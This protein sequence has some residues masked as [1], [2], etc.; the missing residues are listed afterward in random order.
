MVLLIERI[1]HQLKS[2]LSQYLQGFIHSTSCRSSSINS[3]VSQ[4]VCNTVVSGYANL[5]FMTHATEL[6]GISCTMC[7]QY[8]PWIAW[9][10]QGCTETQP[11]W[12]R[13]SINAM[14]IIRKSETNGTNPPSSQFNSIL[15]FQ[16][17]TSTN[18]SN[19]WACP[20]LETVMWATSTHRPPV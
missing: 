11:F 2:K 8:K 12:S 9:D 4:N 17:T 19:P 10:K 13:N 16:Q 1:L 20:F 14:W 5:G 7:Q 6:Q 18:T 3:M 15:Y